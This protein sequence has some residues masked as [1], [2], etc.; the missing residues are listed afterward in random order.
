MFEFLFFNNTN[1]FK[2]I[3]F[4]NNHN[5]SI[6]AILMNDHAISIIDFDIF[7]RIFTQYIFF[8]CVFEL[9]YLSKFKIHFFTDILE[10]LKFENNSRKLRFLLKHKK[11]LKIDLFSQIETNWMHF[12]DFFY[13]Y[14][15][16]VEQNTW[17]EM[18]N[19]Y[20]KQMSNES[21][22]EKWYHNII[23]SCDENF[24]KIMQ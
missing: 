6:F 17:L 12:C 16:R 14:L 11:K 20:L 8:R 19:F 4:I 2:M 13:E 3:I 1:V 22:F 23:K 15:Y 24:T 5:D 18:K 21:K 9:I 7:F 10:I